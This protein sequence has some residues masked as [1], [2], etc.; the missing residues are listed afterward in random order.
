MLLSNFLWNESLG[1]K[2]LMKRKRE[3][4]DATQPYFEGKLLQRGKKHTAL[5]H[6]IKLSAK[7][8][9]DTTQIKAPRDSSSREWL[10]SAS[11][12]LKGQILW[13]V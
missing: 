13:E 5:I 11:K 12:C 2:T 9:T 1:S 7:T 8:P 3:I 4:T 6:P 10:C